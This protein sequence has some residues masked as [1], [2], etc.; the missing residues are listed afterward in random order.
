MSYS[1]N[2]DYKGNGFV[3][4][5]R[6]LKDNFSGNGFVTNRR[7]YKGDVSG[8]GT[9]AFSTYY[10]LP[11]VSGVGQH[12]QSG[13]L[14]TMFSPPEEYDPPA[15]P[16]RAELD[17]I[18][19]V[20][21]YLQ[22]P[23]Y[24]YGD[25]QIESDRIAEFGF[26]WGINQELF[27]NLKLI[28]YDRGILYP[29]SD[30][31]D[32]LK[33]DGF[34]SYDGYTRKFL[35]IVIRSWTGTRFIDFTLPKLVIKDTPKNDDILS[36]AGWDYISEILNQEV[37][38]PAFC[39]LEALERINDG[40]NK[41]FQVNNL[42]NNQAIYELYVNYERITTGWTYNN[43]THIVTFSRA[44]NTNYIVMAKCPVSKQKAIKSICDQAVNKLPGVISPRDYINCSFKF[45][46][47]Y[48]EAELATFN[49]TPKETI[50]KILNSVPADFLIMPSG[51]NL[52]LMFLPK[53]LGDEYP[54][55]GK[56]YIPETMFTAKPDL[57]KSSVRSFNFINLKRP[58]RVYETN[59]PAIMSVQG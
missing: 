10:Q 54:S 30:Y 58:S 4:N 52:K 38:L 39:A 50:K 13:F 34:Y 47:Q 19:G 17:T 26:D 7:P 14:D 15:I 9:I 21:V 42:T 53:I 45:A 20:R 16:S 22:L 27:W 6:P 29:W 8:T 12:R 55:N 56:F 35:K 41:H 28:N 48:F 46:D 2:V 1:L 23:D 24:Y 25:I 33:E 36:F 37:N 43:D 3:T 11:D 44:V 49:T 59:E 5:R 32:F 57:P 31:Y 51:N 40:T 18:T